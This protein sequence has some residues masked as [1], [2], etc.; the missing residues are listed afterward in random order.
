MTLQMHSEVHS[1]LFGVEKHALTILGNASSRFAMRH[2]AIRS[3]L[4]SSSSSSTARRYF[5][6]ELW[7]HTRKSY[8]FFKKVRS[9]TCRR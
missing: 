6:R 7:L 2:R 3:T 5:S 9:I 4:G 8:N 1:N